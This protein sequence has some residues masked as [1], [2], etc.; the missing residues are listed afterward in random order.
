MCIREPTANRHGVLGVEDVRSRRVVDDDRLLE[1]T[2]HLR[3][4]LP[5]GLVRSRIHMARGTCLDIVALVVIATLSEQAVVDY[6][7]DI[8]LIKERIAIL[9]CVRTVGLE[10]DLRTDLPLILKL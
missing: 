3:K 2:S 7:V 8:K 1:V 4:V 9:D 5:N 10:G 6:A